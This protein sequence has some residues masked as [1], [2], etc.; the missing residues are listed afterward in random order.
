MYKAGDFTNGK[1]SE[2][3][4]KA[5]SI[6]GRRKG[7]RIKHKQ[8][9]D[10]TLIHDEDFAISSAAIYCTLRGIPIETFYFCDKTERSRSDEFQLSVISGFFGGSIDNWRDAYFKLVSAL[11]GGY[12]VKSGAKQIEPTEKAYKRMCESLLEA[13]YDFAKYI[14]SGS[15]DHDPVALLFACDNEDIFHEISDY[16]SHQLSSWK[17][18]YELII[19]EREKDEREQAEC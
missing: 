12:S 7:V 15:G 3:F 14:S 5:R 19:S 1:M 10:F 17:D 16:Y 9:G 8:F 18:A 11:M 2:I 13:D 6:N 4:S